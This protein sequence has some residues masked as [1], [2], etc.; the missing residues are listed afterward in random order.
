[1]YFNYRNSYNVIY[2]YP[3]EYDNNKEFLN[4]L[5]QFIENDILINKYEL[6]YKTIFYTRLNNDGKIEHI[7]EG[8]FKFNER[9]YIS[10]NNLKN[11]S[12]NLSVYL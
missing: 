5:I 12:N 7:D 10:I 1:L 3:I 9:R 6:S 4:S 11:Q 8:S 2:R